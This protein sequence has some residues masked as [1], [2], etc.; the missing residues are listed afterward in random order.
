MTIPAY[1]SSTTIAV[2]PNPTLSQAASSTVILTLNSSSA[3][4][5]GSSGAATV[6]IQNI[7]PTLY[8]AAAL[9][10]G[11][12]LANAWHGVAYT[13]IASMA[14]AERAGTAL[15]LENTTVFAAAF[16]APV[17]IPFVLGASS[18]AVVWAVAA[19]AP[20]LAVPLAP[21]GSGLRLRR[22]RT[23]SRSGSGSG[24]EA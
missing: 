22:T 23:A 9:A 20:L 14:G 2:T 16:I 11:G 8:V 21:G 10:V 5:L 18:W 7:A 1:Q 13:E 3:Y 12:L 17:M 19:A 15:G 4:T 24:S 6:T